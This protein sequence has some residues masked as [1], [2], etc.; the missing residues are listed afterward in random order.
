MRNVSTARALPLLHQHEA[1]AVQR[2]GG[3]RLDRG[4]ALQMFDGAIEVATALQRD[5]ELQV[6]RRERRR[7]TDG[8]PQLIDR[9]VC[10]AKLP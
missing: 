7:Q 1:E 2:F 8:A 6:R 5:A 9:L 4:R 10:L 3:G